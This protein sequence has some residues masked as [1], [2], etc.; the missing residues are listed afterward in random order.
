MNLWHLDAVRVTC[1][2]FANSCVTYSMKR[3]YQ[4][5]VAAHHSPS[6]VHPDD[7]PGL[8]ERE[9]QNICHVRKGETVK[10]LQ[11]PKSGES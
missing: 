7:S 4:L 6:P 8:K 5:P 1:S 2:T 9:E 10:A 3:F 11:L